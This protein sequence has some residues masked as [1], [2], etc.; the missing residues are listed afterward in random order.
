V[1]NPNLFVYGTLMSAARHA[2]GA[3]LAREGRLLGPA[4][5]NARLYRIA[6]YPGAVD[7]PNAAERVYGELYALANPAAS[8][9]WLDAYEGLSGGLDASEYARVERRARLLAS[10]E[11]TAWVYL[12]Q[13][14][15]DPRNLIA[16]GRWA[17]AAK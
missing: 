15:P 1:L 17:L 13:G 8:F 16:D 3:K 7:T 5:I 12:Y 2:M 11:L 14:H 6:W 4:S 9:K 10:A